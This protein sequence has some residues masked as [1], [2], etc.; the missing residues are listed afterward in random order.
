MY[1]HILKANKNYLISSPS[2]Q[3]K[4]TPVKSI[5]GTA[6]PEECQAGSSGTIFLSDA[7]EDSFLSTLAILGMNFKQK[8]LVSVLVVKRSVV[9]S[10]DQQAVL[11]YPL[12]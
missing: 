12:I 10:G 5:T 6:A 2:S 1:R 3:L 8:I 4:L 11:T 9:P 7:L